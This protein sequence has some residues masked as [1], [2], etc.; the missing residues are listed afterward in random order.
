MSGP[1]GAD[2]FEPVGHLGLRANC[3]KAWFGWPCDEKI[4]KLRSDFALA[5]DAE[6]KKKIASELQLR[7]VEYVPYW[8][9]AQLY[10]VRA[11]RG[12]VD[13]IVK[14]AVPAYWNIAKK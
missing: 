2:M 9:A 1:T 14:A 3:A 6:L 5:T 11:V 4:E 7:A 10:L 8:P 13:G 12:N